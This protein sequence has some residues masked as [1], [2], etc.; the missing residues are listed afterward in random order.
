MNGNK[1]G[2]QKSK[3]IEKNGIQKKRKIFFL[4]NLL[5]IKKLKKNKFQNSYVKKLL[6][7]FLKFKISITKIILR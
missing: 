3:I 1:V 5:N 6:I 7:Q 2:K 4:K